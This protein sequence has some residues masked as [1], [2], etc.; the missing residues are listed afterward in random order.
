[1][2]DDDQTIHANLRTGSWLKRGTFKLLGYVVVVASLVAAL[3]LAISGTWG[4]I[5]PHGSGPTPEGV[6][7]GLVFFA[8]A[9]G[10]VLAGR[11]IG[12]RFVGK[13]RPQE[14]FLADLILGLLLVAV[15]VGAIF[16][17]GPNSHVSVLIGKLTLG[18][19]ILIVVALGYR[20]WRAQKRRA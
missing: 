20:Y 11:K 5:G 10:V 13:T 12:R 9:V 8:A 4:F 6:L 3:F 19:A 14:G 17:K 1:M 18:P 2:T 16:L 7:L 15:S